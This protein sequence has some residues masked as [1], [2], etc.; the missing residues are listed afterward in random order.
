[1]CRGVPV[2][3]VIDLSSRVENYFPKRTGSSPSVLLIGPTADSP[4]PPLDLLKLSTFLRKRGYSPSLHRGVLDETIPEPH[5]VVLTSV[6]S[7]EVPGLRQLIAGVREYWPR[8]RTIL[9]GVLPRKLGEAA[10]RAFAVNILD[11]RSEIL[12]D[13]ERPDYG[14]VPEWD[15]SIVITS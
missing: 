1:S 2:Q 11:E 8:A 12:L 15:A 13:D 9:T 14:L 5:A 7:W 4:A 3:N 6:F 10:Q